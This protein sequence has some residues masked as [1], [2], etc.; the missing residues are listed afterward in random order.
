MKFKKGDIVFH[1]IFGLCE[2][3]NV[4]P[5]C[6]YLVKYL[7]GNG[8]A[9]YPEKFLKK[10]PAGLNENEEIK[11]AVKEVME[12]KQ[13][14]TNDIVNHPAHYAENGENECIEVM[15]WLFGD[16]AVIAFCRCNIFKYR[17]RCGMKNGKVDIDKAV[18][19]EN[20]LYDMLQEQDG[21]N[22]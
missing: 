16:E 6:T 21:K 1:R 10:A 2:I 17:F 22:D 5:P 18:W 20:Y 4:E 3:I 8:A 13:E 7:T 9:R 12:K 14:H 11:K 15:R 19:Y